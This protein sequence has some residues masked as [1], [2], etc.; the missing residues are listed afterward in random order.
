M[1]IPCGLA[2]LFDAHEA[3]FVPHLK[4]G[5]SPMAL[6]GTSVERYFQ[7]AP[8]YMMPDRNVCA[9]DWRSSRETPTYL[10]ISAWNVIH[11]IGG[12]EQLHEWLKPMECVANHIESDFGSVGLIHYPDT[13][14]GSMWFDTYKFQG[15]DAYCNAADYR[16]FRCMADLESLAGHTD[17]ARRYRENADRIEA[18]YF[19]S[20]Y[21][22]K[23][24]LLAGWRTKD[25]TLHDYM[26]PWVNGFAICQRLVP[27][28]KAKA[29]LQVLLAKLNDIGFHSCQLGLPTNLRPMNPDDYFPHTSGA[30]NQADGMDAWQ[31]YMNGAATPAFEYY[32]IQALYP[33]GQYQEAE[34]LLWPLWQSYEKGTFNCGIILGGQ[35]QRNPVVS[36]FY[37]WNGSRGRGEGYL[38]EEWDG[39][40]ALFTGHYGIG[41]NQHGYYWEPWSPLKGQKIKLDL[42]YMGKNVHYLQPA[43]QTGK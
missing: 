26:F 28:E 7:G 35:K 38:P 42:P 17:L 4:D 27:P 12:M 20:F 5:I 34:R 41:F 36:V 11:T 18:V 2:I 19:I 6:V 16:A 22:P 21:N 1:S 31:I 33:T 40:E 30:P 24:G 25:G 29:I 37:E 43:K 32:V 3:L 39:M 8:G 9:P 10:V 15:A 23:T 13:G 14:H